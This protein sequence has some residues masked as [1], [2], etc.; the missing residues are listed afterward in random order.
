MQGTTKKRNARR[1]SGGTSH[2]LHVVARDR[3]RYGDRYEDRR[4]E[5]RQSSSLLCYIL[6]HRSPLV[7]LKNWTFEGPITPK[8]C[9]SDFEKLP[10]EIL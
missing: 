8:V 5:G 2:S 7:D 6:L 3:D 10:A 1:T 9:F 4:T